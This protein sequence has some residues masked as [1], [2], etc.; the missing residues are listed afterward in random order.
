VGCAIYPADFIRNPDRAIFST[1][2]DS[3]LLT[4][5]RRNIALEYIRRHSL[6]WK[7]Q[8]VS[9]RTVDRL[10]ING[11]TEYAIKKLLADMHRK[12]DIILLDGNF[13]FDLGIPRISVKKGDRRS[14]SIASAS[15]AAKVTRDAVMERFAGIYPGYDFDSSKG[16]GTLK[17]R[18]ALERAAAARFT[19]SAMSRLKVSAL[20]QTGRSDENQ[21]S[22]NHQHLPKG[23]GAPDISG[24]ATWCADFSPRAGALR[25]A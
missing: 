2:N 18:K 25:Q 1:V 14:L 12:P 7:A 10:N 4:P 5:S 6:F 13:S 8:M 23:T 22:R 20:R 15:I 19:G 21:F 3:K 11:A 9:H 24:A 16:Y 17:H